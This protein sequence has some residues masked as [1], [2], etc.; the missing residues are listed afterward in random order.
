LAFPAPPAALLGRSSESPSRRLPVLPRRLHSRTNSPPPGPPPVQGNAEHR[1]IGAE[2]ALEVPEPS[3]RPQEQ[4]CPSRELTGAQHG[5][6]RPALPRCVPVPRCCRRKERKLRSPEQSA[7]EWEARKAWAK[8]GLKP[9]CLFVRRETFVIHAAKTNTW[10]TLVGKKRWTKHALGMGTG[11]NTC[12]ERQGSDNSGRK[13][14]GG[15]FWSMGTFL[16]NDRSE[17]VWKQRASSGYFCS[18]TFSLASQVRAGE[19]ETGP[20]WLPCPWWAENSDLGQMG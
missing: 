7:G 16:W 10:Y 5:R 14:R 12:T 9:G 1:S 4:M 13:M 2:P 3:L 11:G 15:C 17:S 18:V 6:L 20:H 19:W 8:G